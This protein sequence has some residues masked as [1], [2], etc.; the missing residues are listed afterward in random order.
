MNLELRG[1]GKRFG[2]VVAVDGVD[3][4][5]RGGEVL[6]LLGE[7]GAGKSTLVKIVYGDQRAD[8]GELRVDGRPVRFDGPRDARAAGIGMV[9]QQ[10][11][12]VP[13]LTVAENL[14]LAWPSAPRWLPPRAAAWQTVLRTLREIAPEIEP[15]RRA[16]E[17]SVG[18]KQLVELV[19][20]LNLGA[21]L[22]ILDEPTS[23]LAR[24]EAER[25]W[26]Q[27][28]ALARSGA[29]VILI[30]HKLEDV[31][32]CASRVAVMRA[33]RLVG[34]TSAVGDRDTIVGWMMGAAPPPAPRRALPAPAAP[35]I[36]RLVVRGL[37]A[38]EGGGGAVGPATQLDCPALEV[39]AG[40][41]LGVA[42]V[43]GNGQELLGRVLAGVTAPASGTVLLDGRDVRDH[44]VPDAAAGDGAIAYLAEQP[45]L[46]G[47]APELSLMENLSALRVRTLP[48]FPRWRQ[49]RPAASALLERF[50]VRPRDPDR[51][52]GA[53]SGGNLQKMAVARE[54]GQT[55]SLVVSCYPTMGL[56]LAATAAIAGHLLA[57]ADRGAAVVW[58]S[59]ELDQ[60]LEH[61]DRIAVLHGGRLRGP[62]PAAQATR[63][64]L[65]AWMSGAS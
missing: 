35:A 8:A 21:R 37:L 27:I 11:S 57:L 22:V 3:L 12:L 36:P 39:A 6:A 26:T 16:R 55:P 20:V 9:F 14:M 45:S 46:N 30:T 33:G 47:C 42:G 62:V 7:N 56:D 29:A 4:A 19:K 50:D 53:L 51:P 13:A 40:E 24:P 32:A 23:V 38:R 10:F 60:L 43:T 28:R 5:V 49:L 63:A 31:D 17:L 1:I 58:I 61:A 48:F 18:E 54:L 34:E 59:E 2:P 44:G 25:L 41:V 15:S 65:G 52:A 64:S